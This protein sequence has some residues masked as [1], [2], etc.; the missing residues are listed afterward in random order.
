MLDS[1]HAAEAQ[2]PTSEPESSQISVRLPNMA[3][4]FD[5]NDDDAGSSDDEMTLRHSIEQRMKN[6]TIGPALPQFLGKS[7]GLSFIRTA[8]DAKEA[9]ETGKSYSVQEALTDTRP[10][11]WGELPVR[12]RSA[13]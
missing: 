6:L 11:F 3:A 7:S 9:Y 13:R 5:R 1:Q 2:S 12:C 10:E 8:L 4:S